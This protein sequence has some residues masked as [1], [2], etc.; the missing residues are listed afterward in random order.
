MLEFEITFLTKDCKFIW[1]W[2]K[3][4]KSRNKIALQ[5]NISSVILTKKVIGKNFSLELVY[6]GAG[7]GYY[8]T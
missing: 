6:N 5:I 1:A 3:G 4:T 2:C 8:R 7:R